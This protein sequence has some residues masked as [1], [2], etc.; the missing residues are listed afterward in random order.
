MIVK[1]SSQIRAMSIREQIPDEN[2]VGSYVEKNPDK[3]YGES[4]EEAVTV[5]ELPDEDS[6]REVVLAS[7]SQAQS[8]PVVQ[9]QPRRIAVQ[10]E[11]LRGH[12]VRSC[13][14]QSLNCWHCR[15]DNVQ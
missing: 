5:E 15:F 13:F 1:V 9:T 7:S 4:A 12:L 14:W 6:L 11:G 3:F 10:K 8:T 2:Y